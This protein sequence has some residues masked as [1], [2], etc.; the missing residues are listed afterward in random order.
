MQK[1]FAMLKEKNIETI[2]MSPNMMNTY[3]GKDVPIELLATAEDCAACQNDGVLKEY[4]KKTEKIAQKYG[5]YFVNV[6]DYWEK[7]AVLGVDTTALLCNHINHPKREMHTLF[8][9][10]LIE[11][12]KTNNLIG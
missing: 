6:Y 12:I 3:V 11:C 5:V 8:C 9:E 7:L 4:I 10:K 1:M 2:Y